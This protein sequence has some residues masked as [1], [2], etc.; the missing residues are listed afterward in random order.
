MIEVQSLVDG[1]LLGEPDTDADALRQRVT[2]GDKLAIVADPVA[3]RQSVTELLL[4][5]ERELLGE[6][7]PDTE[8]LRQR[9]DEADELANAVAA[10]LCETVIVVEPVE[11]IDKEVDALRQRVVDADMLNNDAEGD[12]V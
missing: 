12:K 5:V 8:E 4:V 9:V 2:E 6:L 11:E 1:V 7:E 3:L 10:A